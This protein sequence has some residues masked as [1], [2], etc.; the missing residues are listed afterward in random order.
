MKL[1]TLSYT[2]ALEQVA[3]LLIATDAL[4]VD[5]RDAPGYPSLMVLVKDCMP[6]FI[7]VSPDWRMD[8]ADWNAAKVIVTRKL[9][10]VGAT[11]FDI[12]DTEELDWVMG[13]I[14]HRTKPGDLKPAVQLTAEQS[15]FDFDTAS[16]TVSCT[17]EGVVVSKTLP[18]PAV[19]SG[20]WLE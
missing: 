17:P 3:S 6:L 8:D 16:Q 7:F 4:V 10:D 20:K 13:E 12:T 15:G 2:E 9:W 11:W 14:L 19:R 1:N 18:Q 5:M